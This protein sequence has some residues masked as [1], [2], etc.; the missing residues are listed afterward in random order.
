MAVRFTQVGRPVYR[1]KQIADSYNFTILQFF[2]VSEVD[3]HLVD[4]HGDEVEVNIHQCSL[5][6]RRI[7]ALE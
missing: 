6:L 5:N 3:I 4:I 2:A 1:M 7:I